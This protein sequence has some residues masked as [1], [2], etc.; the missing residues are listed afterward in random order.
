MQSHPAQYHRGVL[1]NGL[2]KNALCPGCVMDHRRHIRGDG[3]RPTYQ[4]IVHKTQV[5]GA[6]D[7]VFGFQGSGMA[8][9]PSGRP[10]RGQ[11]MGQVFGHTADECGT[12]IDPFLEASGFLFQ[13]RIRIR[14]G[15][16]KGQ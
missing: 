16:T 10:D 14:L 11:L 13:T 15:D 8:L 6:A 9:H 7:L 2:W 12:L 5:E 4:A 3:T 1:V